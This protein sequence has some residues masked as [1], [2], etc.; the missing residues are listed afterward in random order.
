MDIENLEELIKNEVD[1]LKEF[2]QNDCIEDTDFYEKSDMAI[3]KTVDLIVAEM[4]L[5]YEE[6][7][8]EIKEAYSEKLLEE[9][10][11]I[12]DRYSILLNK[13]IQ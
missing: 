5:H 3:E 4:H 6:K 10:Q 1:N 13:V 9:L 2:I 7:I 12:L 11:K 8:S